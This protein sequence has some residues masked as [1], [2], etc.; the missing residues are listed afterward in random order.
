MDYHK[1]YNALIQRARERSLSG[2]FERHHVIPRCLGGSNDASNIVHLLPEEH[3]VAHQLLCK[4]NPGYRGLAAAVVFLTSAGRN[5]VYGWLKRRL[6]ESMKGNKHHLRKEGPA[7]TANQ[8]YMRSERNPQKA[9][10]RCG[11]RHHFYGKKNPFTWSEESKRK[12]SEGKI[13]Q[14]NPMFGIP[15]WENPA[16]VGAANDVWAIAD[17]IMKIHEDH[18]DWGY[19]KVSKSL[20]LDVVYRSLGV[21]NKIKSGWDPLKDPK[22]RKWKDSRK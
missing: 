14:K 20:S 6:S 13:G 4:M 21:L 2:Y 22:W 12:V 3:Y 16:S 15:P 18:P 11:E 5:K 17:K 7:R 8:E 1:H 10:P 19:S 9:N